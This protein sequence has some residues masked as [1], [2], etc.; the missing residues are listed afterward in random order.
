MNHLSHETEDGTHRIS[1]KV[2]SQV[3]S[4][5]LYKSLITILISEFHGLSIVTPILFCALYGG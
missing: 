1:G 2:L 4:S 3:H 5:P